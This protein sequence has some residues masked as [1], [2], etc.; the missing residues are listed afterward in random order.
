M[1]SF[2]VWQTWVIF[3]VAVICAQRQHRVYLWISS[4]CWSSTRASCPSLVLRL[5]TLSAMRSRQD[6]G[7]SGS[8]RDDVFHRLESLVFLF[9]IFCF[10]TATTQFHNFCIYFRLVEQEM[11]S[12]M[13]NER[14]PWWDTACLFRPVFVEHFFPIIFSYKWTSHLGQP[15]ALRP[16]V[17]D[18]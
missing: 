9:F 15:H 3:S 13:L 5:A 16:L 18:V 2:Y 4:A 11:Y 8:G 14:Q 17:L 6:L 12:R 1:S 10:K 7:W